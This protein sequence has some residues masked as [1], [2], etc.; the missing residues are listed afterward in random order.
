MVDPEF[1]LGITDVS[2]EH[3]LDGLPVHHYTHHREMCTHTF[4]LKENLALP[5][6]IQG[7]GK[8][9]AGESLERQGENM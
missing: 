8:K 5:I 9:Q 1:M 7:V 4:T 6:Y 3:I 2:W